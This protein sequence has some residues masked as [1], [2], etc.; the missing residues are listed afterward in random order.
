MREIPKVENDNSLLKYVMLTSSVRK[1]CV[2]LGGS[3]LV[4]CR[5]PTARL[6]LYALRQPRPRQA[7]QSSERRNTPS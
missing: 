1:N 4:F 3:P 6:P 7:V 5:N 2:V